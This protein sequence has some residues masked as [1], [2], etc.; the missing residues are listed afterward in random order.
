MVW[1]TWLWGQWHAGGACACRLEIEDSLHHSNLRF[2]RV[3]MRSRRAWTVYKLGETRLVN[4]RLPIWAWY[5]SLCT[6]DGLSR[7]ALSQ[8]YTA[9]C[10]R[11]TAMRCLSEFVQLHDANGGCADRAN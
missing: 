4:D 8:I 6:T 9:L 5:A 2:W 1:Q 3:T 7:L 10:A 11:Q